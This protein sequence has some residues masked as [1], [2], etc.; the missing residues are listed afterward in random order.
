MFAYS[1]DDKSFYKCLTESSGTLTKIFMI[2]IKVST[3]QKTVNTSRIFHTEFRE[4]LCPQFY[5]R[6]TD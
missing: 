3:N 5:H 4:G 6:V 2:T 1:Q